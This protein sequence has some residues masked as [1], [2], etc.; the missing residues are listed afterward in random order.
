MTGSTDLKRYNKVT[1][2]NEKKDIRRSVQLQ[3]RQG[4]PGITKEDIRQLARLGFQGNE[5]DQAGPAPGGSSKT[6]VK[7]IR[8]WKMS[9][10]PAFLM[11]R[12]PDEVSRLLS[13]ADLTLDCEDCPASELPLLIQGSQND[14]NSIVNQMTSDEA[15]ARLANLYDK[16]GIPEW[17]GIHPKVE[18]GSKM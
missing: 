1:V 11:R 4:H 18:A 9:L 5:A 6:M 15:R 3:A 10:G 8:Q 17:L 13:Q 16:Y 14:P 2:I 12:S 7:R